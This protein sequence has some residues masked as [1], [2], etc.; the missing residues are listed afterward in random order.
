[1]KSYTNAALARLCALLLLLTACVETPPAQSGPSG[2]VEP[3]P[4]EALQADA[5]E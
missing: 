5:A 3:A 4:G 1:M 2:E